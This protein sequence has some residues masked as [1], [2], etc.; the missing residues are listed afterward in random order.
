[1]FLVWLHFE[2]INQTVMISLSLF[3]VPLSAGFQHKLHIYLLF[4]LCI[5]LCFIWCFLCF[6]RLQDKVLLGDNK[7]W[8]KPVFSRLDVQLCLQGDFELS[9]S[10]LD[11]TLCHSL[12]SGSFSQPSSCDDPWVNSW[13]IVSDTCDRL[14]FSLAAFTSREL[15]NLSTDVN[16]IT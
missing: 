2:A 8:R 4:V 6:T 13:L 11:T 15:S 3:Y 10:S 9:F 14:R 5:L 16:S 7:A 12:S 1:M